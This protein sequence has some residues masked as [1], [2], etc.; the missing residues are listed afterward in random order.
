MRSIFKNKLLQAILVLL[1]LHFNSRVFRVELT[2]ASTNNV[3]VH[4]PDTYVIIDCIMYNGE[5]ILQARLEML[6]DFIDR[7]YITESLVTHSGQKKE[8]L[9]MEINSDFFKPYKN[10]ITWHIYEP[11]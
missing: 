9:F 4:R 5:P 7:F 2:T 6:N 1:F 10:K 11:T 8:K 3:S